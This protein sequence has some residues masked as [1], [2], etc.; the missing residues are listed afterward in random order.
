M[1]R[2]TL[3][4]QNDVHP[5][6]QA[7]E[8][9]LLIRLAT[10][11][12]LLGTL[13]V[14]RAL[15]QPSLSDGTLALTY[16]LLFLG[17]LFVFAQSLVMTWS[18]RPQG[19]LYLGFAQIV[20]HLGLVQVWVSTCANP[21]TPFE[22]IYFLEILFSSLI[23][24]KLGALVAFTTSS[25]VLG[26]HVALAGNVPRPLLTWILYSGGFGTLAFLGSLFGEELLSVAEK[27]RS[28]QA[29]IESLIALHEAILSSMPTGLLSVDGDLRVTYLNPAGERILGSKAAEELTGQPLLS[30]F[31]DLAKVFLQPHRA[32]QKARSDGKPITHERLQQV[33]EFQE[34]TRK[35]VLRGDVAELESHIDLGDLRSD[36]WGGGQAFLFQDV[37]ALVDLEKKLKQHEKLAAV[38]QLAAG[39]AHEIRNPLA[40]M[41]G[42]IEILLQSLNEDSGKKAHKEEDAKLMRIIL[43]EIDRLNQLISDFLA[44]VRPESLEFQSLPLHSLILDVVQ[45]LLQSQEVRSRITFHTEGMRPSWVWGHPDRMRQIVWNLLSNSVQ[46]I[47]A[48]GDIYLKTEQT[49]DGKIRLWVRD[50]GTGI[51][52]QVM[53]HLFEPFLQPSRKGRGLGLPPCISSS[54][55]TRAKFQL[56]PFLGKAPPF[57]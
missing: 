26:Y 53:P 22:L 24:G 39:I 23:L 9:A 13:F 52:P 57:S 48:T 16:L 29:K 2:G 49:H 17:F 55:H 27:L 33:V 54:R 5:S 47:V 11:C 32:R 35:R 56:S 28:K 31:P 1:A 41:S 6:Q 10:L 38:G 34:P 20:A 8:H 43:R 25:L 30:S 14:Q 36:Q 50:S 3:L 7:L 15:P 12:V 40:S 4:S 46:A 42:S 51:S 45:A 21:Q 44:F 37:T 19:L 18:T